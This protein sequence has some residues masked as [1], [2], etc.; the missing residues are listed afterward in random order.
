MNT[1]THSTIAML[2]VIN[3]VV[4]GIMMMQLSKEA[5]K[6]SNIISGIKAMIA[7]LIILLLAAL[8]GKSILSAFGISL[9]AFKVVGG[10]ILSFLGLQ[11]MVG[12]KNTNNS[13][14]KQTGLTPLIMFA[15][16]PGTIAMVITLSVTH[17]ATGLPISAMLGSAFAVLITIGIMVAMELLSKQGKPHGQGIFSKFVGLIIVAMGIQFI[18]DGI[19]MFFG[20]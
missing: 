6:K 14:D 3:P 7:V 11:M 8:G 19:K 9:D 13:N 16:S 2:A 12:P 1:Y 18:L 15:A 4:C 5:S 17:D 10:I 20:I